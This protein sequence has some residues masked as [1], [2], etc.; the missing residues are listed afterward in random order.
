[1]DN[2][3]AV[4][5]AGGMGGRLWPISRR[6]SPKQLNPFLDNADT[7]LQRTWK[8]VRKILPPEQ[9]Y[10]STVKGYEQ[11][12][13]NQ[14][15]EFLLSNL[16]IEPTLRDTTAAIGLTTTFIAKRHPGSYM[17]NVW[18][19]HV[20][21]E[22]DKFVEVVKKLYQSLQHN[23]DIIMSVGVPIEYPYTGYGYLEV[24]PTPIADQMFKVRRFVE[25][26]N[27]IDAQ[28]YMQAGNYYWNPAL[29]MWRAEHMLQLYQQYVPDMYA[30]LMTIQHA[31]DTPDYAD[32]VKTVYPTFTKVAVD[33]AIFEKSPAMQLI[34]ADLGWRDVGSWQ[35]VYEVLNGDN[36]EETVATKGKVLTLGCRDTLVFNEDSKKLVTVVGLEDVAIINTLDAILVVKK[37]RDQEVKGLV[38]YLEKEEMTE[39]L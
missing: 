13:I 10:L 21:K 38:T 16:I 36:K 34:P 31:I 15:P 1:M 25:K 18:S 33:Y 20:Y 32:L 35:S 14:L 19:D 26:P 5:F 23:H 12:I 3:Y 9:I 37:S 8:R 17:M 24:D 2:L 6:N 7:L 4:I 28:K 27:L 29:W 11:I 30:G 22:E 39:Y